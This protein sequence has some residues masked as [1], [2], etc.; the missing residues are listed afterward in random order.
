MSLLALKSMGA[1][2]QRLRDF[3]NKYSEHLEKRRDLTV[4]KSF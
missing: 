2:S 1:D 3:F 4:N